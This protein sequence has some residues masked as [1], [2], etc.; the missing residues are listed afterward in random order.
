MNYSQIIEA[1]NQASGFDLFRIQSAIGNM[2]DDPRRIQTLK[3]A[4]AVGQEI[5]YFEP[6]QNRAIRAKLIAFKRTRVEVEDLEG[7][8]RWG[9]PY[10]YINIHG[11][12]TNINAQTRREGL[13]R[14]EVKVGDKVGFLD[15]DNKECY[16]SIVRLNQK[17]VTIDT[18]DVQWRVGYSHLFKVLAPDL[19]ALPGD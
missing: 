18:P 6:T 2:L 15:K 4:L 16:G 9:L 14:N 7:G 3:Q 17:S 13:D 8:R 1:L 5:E 11:V 12:D 19:D 10:Y